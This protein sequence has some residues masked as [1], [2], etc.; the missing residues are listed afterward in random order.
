MKADIHIIVLL[1]LVACV[2][3]S[4]IETNAENG[5]ITLIHGKPLILQCNTTNMPGSRIVWYHREKGNEP[6]EDNDFLKI[7]KEDYSVRIDK[8]N[9]DRDFGHYDCIVAI[10]EKSLNASIVVQTEVKVEAFHK[11][12][13]LVQ[14][15]KLVLTCKAKGYPPPTINWYKDNM[16][17]NDSAGRIKFEMDNHLKDAKLIIEELEYEDRA[18]Y[19]CEASSSVNTV[20]TTIIVRVKDKLAALWPFLGICAEVAILCT[21]IFVYEKKRVKPDFDESDT[22]NNPENKNVQDQK[23]AGQDVRQR[24]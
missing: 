8:P 21:I 16:P 6:L 18:N 13:N 1:L 11:S 5:V 17:L 12:L 4:E 9:E 19:L 22:D 20:N 15:D 3:G 2:T 14:G 23:E 24:K 7:N 10:E